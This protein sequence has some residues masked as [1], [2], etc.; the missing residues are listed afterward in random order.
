MNDNKRTYK[1][2]IDFDGTITT[3][4]VGEM[5][6]LKFGDAQ[7]ANDIIDLWIDNEINSVQS[8]QMLCKTVQNF[9]SIKFDEFIN[10]IQIDEHF[11][12]FEKFCGK[13]NID[14]AILSDGLDYY[15]DRILAKEG[16]DH[17]KRFSNKLTF[18]DTNNLVPVF[19]YTDENCSTCANCKRNHIINNSSDN[20]FTIYVGDGYS[21][22]C[23][24]QYCDFIFAKHSLLKYCE[25]NRISYFPFDNFSDV[26]KRVEELIARKRLKKRYQAELK[27]REVYLLG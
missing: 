27:R 17:L 11:K 3:E 16:F 26:Q 15:I 8:W 19:P 1:I 10:K 25:K 14:I 12:T 21:D 20:D 24:A 9:D 2:F 22:T 5:M 6:F 4:D 7:K 18:D 13:N 23:P